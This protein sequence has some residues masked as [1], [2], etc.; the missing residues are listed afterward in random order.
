MGGVE[1]LNGKEDTLRIQKRFGKTQ[2]EL[3]NAGWG[4]G[5]E[6]GVEDDCR[7]QGCRC[8]RLSWLKS[9]CLL[10]YLGYILSSH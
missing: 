2:T 3:S 8:L 1:Q 6:R 10:S 7:W 5:G 4:G 9:L